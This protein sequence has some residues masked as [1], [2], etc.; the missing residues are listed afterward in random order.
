MQIQQIENIPCNVSYINNGLCSITF[1]IPQSDL[2]SFVAIL[3]GLSGLFR[4]CSYKA[5]INDEIIHERIEK[6]QPD[7]EKRNREFEADCC[8]MYCDYLKREQNPWL[9]FSLT[10]SKIKTMYDFSSYD[11]VKKC[12]TKNKYLKKTGFYSNRHKFD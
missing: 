11:I 10:V 7:I 1:Q 12:L 2:S 8:K 9:A 3:S 4:S 6:K 5:K